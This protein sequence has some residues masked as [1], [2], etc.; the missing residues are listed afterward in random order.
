MTAS[1]SVPPRTRRETSSRT[2]LVFVSGGKG[3]VGKTTLACHAA[4]EL[5]RRGFRT[6]L[7]DLD[8]ALGDVAVALRLTP[9]KTLEDALVRGEAL[10]SCLVTLEDGLDVLCAPSGSAPL[11]ALDAN[12][13]ES[14]W[15]AVR[16]LAASYDVCIADGGPG[17]GP[18]V[19]RACAEADRVWVV[20]THE[21]AS[22][23]DAY[24]LVKALHT[25]GD[26]EGRDVPTPEIVVN[27]ARGLEDAEA[28]AQKLRAVCERFLARSPACAGWLPET[29]AFASEVREPLRARVNGALAALCLERLVQRIE[30][31]IGRRES[32]SGSSRASFS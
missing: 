18:D 17:A 6:L 23:A 16:A 13:R 8:L 1:L 12:A 7:V 9:Q 31:G 32:L 19:L 22:I 21:A 11:G 26:G 24:G 27:R 3:G 30:R 15:R 29:T 14:L 5:S 20:A 25:W 2:P 28:L 4:L 10:E